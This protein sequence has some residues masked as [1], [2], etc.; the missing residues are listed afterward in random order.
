MN[1]HTH[2]YGYDIDIK[3]RQY[4]IINIKA[5]GLSNDITV[6]QADFKNFTQP[7]EKS[8]LIVSPPL[9]EKGFP[10]RTLGT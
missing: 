7:K 8:I 4:N 10:R 1:S 9:Q 3:G 6:E 2:I 5:A